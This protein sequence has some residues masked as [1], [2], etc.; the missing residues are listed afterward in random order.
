MAARALL[1]LYIKNG[2]VYFFSSKKS[3][4][5]SLR[6]KEVNIL[7]KKDILKYFQEFVTNNNK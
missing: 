7:E 1:S 2:L 6:E 5:K 3:K 4:I